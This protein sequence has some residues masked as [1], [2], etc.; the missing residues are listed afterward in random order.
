MTLF[1]YTTL[2]RSQLVALTQT[3]IMAIQKNLNPPITIPAAE[4]F[5]HPNPISVKLNGRNYSLWSQV[6]TMY[7]KGRDKLQHI[8]GKPAPPQSHDALF[9]KWDIDDTVVK[10][11]LINS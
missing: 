4:T 11:W 2:F 10:G 9:P 5:I 8:I 1:P 7:V 3:Q 6:V